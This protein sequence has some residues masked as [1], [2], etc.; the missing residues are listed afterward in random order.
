MK[1][2]KL[3]MLVAMVLLSTFVVAGCY[4]NA[5][6]KSAM[7]QKNGDAMMKDEDKAME[8][9]DDDGAMDSD[10]QH[11]NL[12]G[13]NFEFSQKEIRVKKGDKIKITFSSTDGFHE[14]VV[15]EFN[16]KT[17]RVNTGEETSV[18]FTVDQTGTF[19]YYCSV[20]KHRELGMVGQ[21]IVE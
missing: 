4:N 1:N 18:E 20:G 13:K 6:E 5:E 14:W 16:A 8:E 2:K 17:T 12:T 21:L 9:K 11:F 19:E 7:E 15:D 10:V 3:F